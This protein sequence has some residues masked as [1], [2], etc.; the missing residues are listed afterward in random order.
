MSVAVGRTLRSPERNAALAEVAQRF[1]GTVET[2]LTSFGLALE[3]DALHEATVR[4][5]QGFPAPAE[6]ILAACLDG[7]GTIV[8]GP[9]GEHERESISALLDLMAE[10]HGLDRSL[11]EIRER[12]HRD[13]MV[14]VRTA[15]H[16]LRSAEATTQMIDRAVREFCESCGFDRCAAFRMHESGLVVQ[17]ACFTGEEE[18][19][20]R[21]QHWSEDHPARLQPEDI[22]VELIRRQIPVLAARPQQ[23]ARGM[24]SLVRTAETEAYVAAPIVSKGKVVGTLHADNLFSGRPLDESDRDALGAFAEGFAFALERTA[25]LQ[26]IRNERR[27][28]QQLMALADSS[29]EDLS[30]GGIDFQRGETGEIVVTPQG[31]PSLPPTSGAARL[32]SLLTPR[33]L[34][35]LELMGAGATNA[36]IADR[37]VIS[38]ATVKS[39]VKHILRKLRA[40]NRAEAVSKFC[41]ISAAADV[42]DHA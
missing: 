41:R 22:E 19:A 11:G 7:V 5:A 30:S 36:M 29:L 24:A 3:D 39:H 6:A 25:L 18:W 12:R 8:R 17:A 1:A 37:L 38:G 13:Q 15:L 9:R 26:G 34:E 35:V 33:E 27:R 2:C 10:L 32:A 31:V 23:T 42:L 20:E 4:L 16:R 40:A 28:V 21:W 14:G